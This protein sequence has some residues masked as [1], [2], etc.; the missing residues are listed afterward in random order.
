MLQAGSAYRLAMTGR[1]DRDA[2]SESPADSQTERT[3]VIVTTYGYILR[4]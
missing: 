3:A 4:L 2:I 1:V